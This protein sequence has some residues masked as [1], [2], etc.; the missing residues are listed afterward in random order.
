MPPRV[1]TAR[2]RVCS[3]IRLVCAAVL[4][5]SFA[6]PEEVPRIALAGQYFALFSA[7]PLSHTFPPPT[8]AFP[9]HATRL[10]PQIERSSAAAH[11][12]VHRG[13]IEATLA[14]EV[15]SHT[16]PICYELMVPPVRI[17]A[18]L[19]PVRFARR[20]RARRVG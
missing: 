10:C 20:A 7:A 1:M 15:A 2:L 8:P 13:R 4:R 11:E 6:R 3:R 19:A 18:S 16:C 12:E 9:F 17:F 5:A 14:S